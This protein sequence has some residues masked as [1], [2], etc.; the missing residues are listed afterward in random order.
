M[1]LF[2]EAGYFGLLLVLMNQ[3]IAVNAA[4][5]NRM[6]KNS[7]IQMVWGSM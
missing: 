5:V 1:L 3:A 2:D 7:R 4:N 6:E